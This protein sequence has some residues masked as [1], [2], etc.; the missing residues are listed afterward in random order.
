MDDRVSHD[1]IHDT[2]RAHG[3][4][5]LGTFSIF[6]DSMCTNGFNSKCHAW[7]IVMD[8]ITSGEYIQNYTVLFSLVCTLQYSTVQYSR[9]SI[10]KFS[11][12]PMLPLAT[13]CRITRWMSQSQQIATIDECYIMA[14][15]FCLSMDLIVFVAIIMNDLI[16]S[17]CLLSTVT[18]VV[19]SYLIV[20][21]G[22]SCTL[23]T[24]QYC[25]WSFTIDPIMLYCKC[26]HCVLYSAKRRET[27]LVH[28]TYNHVTQCTVLYAQY[29]SKLRVGL[30]KYSTPS[31]HGPWTSRTVYRIRTLPLL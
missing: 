30:E 20:W 4:W 28:V 26:V 8:S 23:C 9:Y 22:L 5:A 29:C 12:P 24:L 17:G 18:L 19:V 7:W 1:Y 3:P 16:Q 31:C 10:F 2:H 6:G 21:S 15:C 11:R 14:I 27:A 25:A 13:A